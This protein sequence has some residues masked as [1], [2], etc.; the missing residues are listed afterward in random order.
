MFIICIYTVTYKLTSKTLTKSMTVYFYEFTGG[1]VPINKYV[2][3]LYVIE[4]SYLNSTYMIIPIHSFYL[5]LRFD[6]L[7]YY[8]SSFDMES[9]HL[10]MLS[11]LICKIQRIYILCHIIAYSYYL[12]KFWFQSF[13][14]LMLNLPIVYLKI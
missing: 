12:W 4:F 13:N 7:T 2:N 6:R 3:L 10:Y 8:Y 11:I 14:V 9:I 5:S 1:F